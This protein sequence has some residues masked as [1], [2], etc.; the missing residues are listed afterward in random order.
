MAQVGNSASRRWLASAVALALAG[1]IPLAG[2]H[3]QDVGLDQQA[4]EAAWA[5]RIGDGL[6]LMDRHLADHPEDRAARLDRA[7]FLAWRGDYAAASEALDAA[8]GDDAEVRGLRA[9]IYAWAHRREMA[10]ALSTPLYESDPADFDNA[11]TQ[12][13]AARLGEWPHESLQA[14]AEV[15]AAQP[16]GSDTRDLARAVRL[17]LFSSVGVPV[18]VYD[19]SDDIRIRSVGVDGELRLGDRWRLLAQGKER[20]HSAPATGPFAPVT[21]GS[22]VDET[23]IGV[24][25]RYAPSPRSTVELLVG[26]S[27]LSPGRATAI[28]HA[29]W[30]HRLDDAFKYTLRAERDRVAAS[31]RSLSLGVTRDRVGVATEWL[32]TLRDTL[33]TSIAFDDLSDGNRRRGVDA[34]YRH[35]A[36]RGERVNVDVGGQVEWSGYSSDPGNGYYSPDRYLRVAPLASAYVKLG[37]D[38]GLYVQGTLGAQRD[39]SFGSWKRAAD[40]S[41]ELTVGIFSH[42]QLVAQA[43]YSERFNEFGGYEG[44]RV[45]LELRYRFCEF[46]SDR[47]PQSAGR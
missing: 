47:C 21:G 41:G 42:W 37:D 13:L 39:E 27:E 26:R 24:G 10:L 32:P 46:R 44:T 28:G 45:G 2:S 29:Q 12:A 19:D 14:L 38:V 33:R 36:Y 4:R 34:D 31:P 20:E 40:V 6:A 17:P 35:A 8:G 25:L 18:S 22:T 7:R 30:S 11:Y 1:G 15:V 16:E 23:R 5:G 3:A 43:G 9:R